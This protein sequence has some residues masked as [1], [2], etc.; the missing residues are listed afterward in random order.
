MFKYRGNLALHG[1][2]MAMSEGRKR[3]CRRLENETSSKWAN[4]TK[5]HFT[6]Q[7][8]TDGGLSKGGGKSHDFSKFCFG[9][10]IAPKDS[11]GLRMG[12][13]G[14]KNRQESKSGIRISPKRINT[15]QKPKM[16]NRNKSKITPPHLDNPPSG[17]L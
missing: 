8:A 11:L 4:L 13:T 6:V 3:K 10:K 15:E 9:P 2:E 12:G 16:K 1:I 14:P 5:P 17:P 7:R